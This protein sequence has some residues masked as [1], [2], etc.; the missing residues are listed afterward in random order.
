MQSEDLASLAELAAASSSLSGRRRWGC[1]RLVMPRYG[2]YAQT[3]AA[4]QGGVPFE[5][6]AR[7]R[8]EGAG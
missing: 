5:G 7:T 8:P 4:R 2:D 3:I 1:V 6:F